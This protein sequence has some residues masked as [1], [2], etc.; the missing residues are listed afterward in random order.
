M[1]ALSRT[2]PDERLRLIEL[3]RRGML[4]DGGSVAPTLPHWIASSWQRCLARGQRPEQPVGFDA[5]PA[6]QLRRV[7]EANHALISVARPILQRLARAIA[8]TRYFA[9]LV[10]AEGVVVDVNGP[11]DRSQ[12]AVQ[13][14]TRIGVDLSE[15]GVGTSAIGAALAELQPVWLHRGEH[16]FADTSVYSCAG[17]P[18]FGPDGRCIGMLDLTGVMVEERPELKHLVAQYARSIEDALILQQGH[19]LVL[20]LSWPGQVPGE[21]TDGLLGIDEEGLVRAANRAA[22]EMLPPLAVAGVPAQHLRDLFALPPGLLF[23]ASQH[24]ATPLDVP[25]WSG[26]RLMV[27]ARRP[28]H[29]TSPTASAPAGFAPGP[30]GGHETLKDVED[31]LIRDAVAAARGNVAVA[32]RTLGISRATVYRKLARRAPGRG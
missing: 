6:Q 16:F 27:L 10:N 12:R 2:S 32:A 21:A 28:G 15:S 30:A 25:L 9:I 14:I 8:D 18:L 31:A 24:G 4:Q 5:L 11:I 1:H 29:A 23:D 7:E 19:A 20:R 17:A 3:A 26:L 13:V 22:R